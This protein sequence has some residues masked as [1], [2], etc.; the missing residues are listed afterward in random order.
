[1][2][3]RHT[4]SSALS[5][6]GS[7]VARLGL[8]LLALVLAK[9][10]AASLIRAVLAGLGRLAGVPTTCVKR[11]SKV[12]SERVHYSTQFLTEEGVSCSAS[13]QAVGPL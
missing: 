6:V 1:M 11:V 4:Y 9:A 13:P 12:T 8:G 2:E 5:L 10:L 3:K 7:A